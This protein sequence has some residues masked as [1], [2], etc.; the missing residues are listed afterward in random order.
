[1]NFKKSCSSVEKKI[2][3]AAP[4][5]KS[6]DNPT[7][8]NPLTGVISRDINIYRFGSREPVAH[9]TRLVLDTPPEILRYHLIEVLFLD[10]SS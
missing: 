3:V 4:F 8:M 9:P 6:Y 5:D 10:M 2:Y 7:L 1:M